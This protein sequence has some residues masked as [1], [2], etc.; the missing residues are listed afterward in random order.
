MNVSSS[1]QGTRSCDSLGSLNIGAKAKK[2]IRNKTSPPLRQSRAGWTSLDLG[3]S[4]LES[5]RFFPGFSEI[6]PWFLGDIL[7]L[8]LYSSTASTSNATQHN[9]QAFW[10][11]LHI[12]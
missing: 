10:L 2:V 8:A 4:S 9:M 11:S 7:A 3:D 12:G 5:H 1:L 6:L